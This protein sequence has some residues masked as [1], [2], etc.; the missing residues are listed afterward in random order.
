MGACCLPDS[1]VI[2]GENECANAQ[3]GPG[4]FQGAGSTCEEC[5]GA[6][7]FDGGCFDGLE[8]ECVDAEFQ[9]IGTNCTTT[10]CP[11]DAPTPAPTPTDAPTPMP[12]PTPDVIGA[13]CLPDSCVIVGE[14]E[15]DSAQFGPGVFQGAGSTC[16]ECQGACCFD[17]GC[18]DGFEFDCVDAAFQGIGTNCSTV[19]C[20]T[21]A[22]TPAP[23]DAPTPAP[24]DA[25]TP[26][27][28]DA[29]TPA[30]TPPPVCEQES[31]C[32][33]RPGCVGGADDGLFCN[34]VDDCEGG[35]EC[36]TL[37]QSCNNDAPCL[38]CD[39][40]EDDLREHQCA[41]CRYCDA[42][43]FANV[44]EHAA[45]QCCP[46]DD[47]L[48][49]LDAAECRPRLNCACRNCVDKC[50][51]KVASDV[52]LTLPAD[53]AG[54]A[55]ND[56]ATLGPLLGLGDLSGKPYT[57]GE[58]PRSLCSALR[59]HSCALERGLYRVASID[60][61]GVNSSA[62]LCADTLYE[63]RLY[64]TY[65][66]HVTERDVSVT[67]RRTLPTSIDDDLVYPIVYLVDGT[68]ADCYDAFVYRPQTVSEREHELVPVHNLGPGGVVVS[69]TFTIRVPSTGHYVLVVGF[70]EL[71][72]TR[73][74]APVS[75]D[76]L[77]A[78]RCVEYKVAVNWQQPQCPAA[79]CEQYATCA[80]SRDCPVPPGTGDALCNYRCATDYG[81][82]ILARPLP[83]LPALFAQHRKRAVSESVCDGQVDGA[84]CL[85]AALSENEED[86]VRR[87]CSFG[88]CSAGQ[89]APLVD[90]PPSFDCDCA[91][92]RECTTFL[93]CNDCDP[94]TEDVCEHETGTCINRPIEAGVE[95]DGGT[96]DPDDGGGGVIDPGDGGDGG[97]I[98]NSGVPGVS[99]PVHAHTSSGSAASVP[100][101]FDA[102]GAEPAS[103]A[104]VLAAL[105][106]AEL[107][108]TASAFDVFGAYDA[109]SG[110][111]L[112][113]LCNADVER[114]EIE[115]RVAAH[116]SRACAADVDMARRC[117]DGAARAT[118]NGHSWFD[119]AWRALDRASR[120][121]Q[122][123]PSSRRALNDACCAH[124]YYT[125]LGAWCGRHDADADFWQLAGARVQR[126]ALG[127]ECVAFDDGHRDRDLND[128]VAEQRVVEVRASGSGALRAVNVHVVPLARGGG[129]HTSYAVSVRGT[130]VATVDR[131]AGAACSERSRAL[132][133]DALD[134]DELAHALRNRVGFAEGAH[135]GVFHHVLN[136]RSAT[137]HA[138][139][140]GVRDSH[141]TTIG[142]R[143]DAPI[144]CP[145]QSAHGDVAL[146]DSLRAV[147]PPQA[148]GTDVLAGE[149]S[150]IDNS[151][152]TRR[153]T[154]RVP[155]AFGASAVIVPAPSDAT[156]A[157]VGAH[158]LRF[159]LRNEDCGAAVVLPP[160]DAPASA[161]PPL[162]VRVPA[163]ACAAWRWTDEGVPLIDNPAAVSGVCRG[164]TEGGVLE[165]DADGGDD[166]RALCEASGGVCT[167]APAS[168]APLAYA[169]AYK[170]YTCDECRESDDAVRHWYEHA[171]AELLYEQPRTA[172]ERVFG[173]D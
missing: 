85:L 115:V 61:H 147:L 103:D 60:A 136:A 130:R 148:R 8:F 140:L 129:Y 149:A 6:C 158:S 117:L 78:L 63:K 57:Q 150:V 32:G 135:V 153:A 58:L 98:F 91:C 100:V 50:D 29:P 3:F 97:F 34:S 44:D 30:P 132:L 165:C 25:P 113:P 108:Y 144:Y 119:R 84:P 157:H 24:T 120:A 146:F 5:R 116:A 101:D 56:T 31:V 122:A 15:C 166:A 171:N 104:R 95:D 40:D 11:T 92:A 151:V 18:F 33:V 65:R 54:V 62:E 51:F 48:P 71:R 143:D 126:A 26:A 49:P 110:A 94:N 17:G 99:G 121:A 87:V 134:A 86:A 66:V 106:A 133:H 141:C 69:Q 35:T 167:E 80:D 67:L 64:D 114:R 42:E 170:Y 111:R 123:L 12:T 164:G 59:H 73:A 38:D 2:I 139:P 138:L 27:P 161:T 162:A 107:A 13:C 102:A 37:E 23:T 137:E 155:P 156:S 88:A 112:A 96:V 172:H 46:F 89:C 41:P 16:D 10:E 131:G 43:E 45:I 70:L 55:E 83:E 90:A 159:V 128:F 72:T 14:S 36:V 152:N 68:D 124:M 154:R 53:F 77:R 74:G 1:C 4:A 169:H 20:P 7:C 160:H 9:G 109:R 142:A 81:R 145:Q 76:A 163:R 22:P 39:S 125:A 47:P 127:A 105:D 75:D 21:D 52:A 28:T 118:A 173:T 79:L 168:G 19:E 82:C 93:D